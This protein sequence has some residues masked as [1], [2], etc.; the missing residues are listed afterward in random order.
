MSDILPPATDLDDA[1]LAG[2][3]ELMSQAADTNF[4]RAVADHLGRVASTH[5][6]WSGN[7]KVT[8]FHSDLPC[9]DYDEALSLGVAWLMS[10]VREGL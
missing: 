4:E 9:E 8:H 3:A 10:K 5:D 1:T 7:C 6:L 2:I